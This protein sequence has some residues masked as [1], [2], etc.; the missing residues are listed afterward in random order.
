MKAPGW[1]GVSAHR[2][3]AMRSKRATKRRR[4]TSEAGG[5]TTVAITSKCRVAL[6]DTFWRTSPTRK[7]RDDGPRIVARFRGAIRAL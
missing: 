3:S 6:S 7:E 1:A 4:V 2:L 5:N